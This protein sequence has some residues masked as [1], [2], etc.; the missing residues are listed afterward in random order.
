[1]ARAFRANKDQVHLVLSWLREVDCFVMAAPFA[2]DIL[3]TRQGG[4]LD[5]L[6]VHLEVLCTHGEVSPVDAVVHLG[7]FV[8]P[9]IVVAELAHELKELVIL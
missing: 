2:D 4:V 9:L 8:R 5:A 3:S 6:G 1:M 7:V